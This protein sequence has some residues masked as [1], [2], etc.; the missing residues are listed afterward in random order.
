MRQPFCVA[1]F[2][3]SC[4][5]ASTVFAQSQITTGVIDGTVIDASNAVLPGV[6][7]EVRNVDTGLV[8]TFTTGS[9][10]RFLAL[11]LPT[12]RYTVTITLAG[13]ATL[14]QE[15]VLVTVGESV[16]LNSTMKVSGIAETVTVSTESPVVETSRTASSS[17]LDREDHRDDADSRAQVRGSADAHAGC[18]HRAGARRRRDYV[19]R[20]ARRVQQHQPRRRRLHKRLLRRAGRRAARGH[21]HHAR[22]RQGVPGHRDRRQRRVRPHRGRRR[23]RDHQVGHQPA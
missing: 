7:V 16:R 15:N 13:F 5:L 2:V 10:G 22:G 1:T 4:L 14:V 8:R 19:R 3:V 21:R 23:Q 9:D 6:T 12:G 18:E 17:T 20:A 11:Q